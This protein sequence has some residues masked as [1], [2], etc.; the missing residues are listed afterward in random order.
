MRRSSRGEM[1]DREFGREENGGGTCSS[2]V[3]QTC[4]RSTRGVSSV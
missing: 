2:M 1:G 3:R 4:G